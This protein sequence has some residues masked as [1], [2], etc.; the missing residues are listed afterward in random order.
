MP[1]RSPML[2]A[3]RRATSPMGRTWRCRSA[4]IGVR[5]RRVE[6]E[7]GVARRATRVTEGVALVVADDAVVDGHDPVAVEGNRSHRVRGI[8]AGVQDLH[9]VQDVFRV[10][11]HDLDLE[12]AS[13]SPIALER[14]HVARRSRRLQRSRDGAWAV[15]VMHGEPRSLSEVEGDAADP[16]RRPLRRR[17]SSTC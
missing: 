13:R 7:V 3:G 14:D 8:G 2:P 6:C 17:P 12:P 10:R 4:A 9:V 1:I 15:G 11:R 16:P 5:V